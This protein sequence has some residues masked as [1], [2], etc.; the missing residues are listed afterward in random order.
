M[1]LFIK[2]VAKLGRY[3]RYIYERNE[4]DGWIC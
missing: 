1:R 2:Y 4:V 3:L